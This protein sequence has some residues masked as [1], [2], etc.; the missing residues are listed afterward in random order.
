MASSQ[1][2]SMSL[3]KKE[4]IID[5]RLFVR[6]IVMNKIESE[7]EDLDVTEHVVSRIKQLGLYNL[8]RQHSEVFDELLVEEFYQNA[9][10]RLHSLKKG[11]DAADI[12]AEVRGVEICINYHL[13]KDIF[14]LPSPGLNMEE[15]ESFRWED[16][17]T[18]FCGLFIDDGTD[19]KVHPSC[20]KKLFLLPLV[21]L[22]VFCCRV[23]SNRTGAFNMCINLR[24]RMMVAIMFGKPVN[25]CQIMLKRLQKEVS[26][27]ASQK[28]SFERKVFCPDKTGFSEEIVHYPDELKLP[29]DHQPS[30]DQIKR[31]MK[32]ELMR[33]FVNL[34]TESPKFNHCK[35]LSEA[36]NEFSKQLEKGMLP[37]QLTMLSMH[38]RGDQVTHPEHWILSFDRS[39]EG[40]AVYQNRCKGAFEN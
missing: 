28:K 34:I 18:T 15:L 30:A 25:W 17:L 19:K 20:H 38:R 23:V 12:S 27:P 8:G 5:G 13:L 37:L 14:G 31:W 9:S 11:G 26:K 4:S 21:Y 40:R 33:Y 22:Y 36:A 6:S 24:F 2:S 39:Y 1:T 3:K 10:V 16:L 7:H 35:T 29:T 32:N